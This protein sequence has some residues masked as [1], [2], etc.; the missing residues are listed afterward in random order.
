LFSDSYLT[1]WK[2]VK[3]LTLASMKARYRKTIAGFLWVVASPIILYCI[4]SVVFRKFLKLDIPDYALFLLGGL[5]PWI[6]LSSTLEMCTPMFS[7]RSELLKSF[8][9]SPFVLI[10]SQILDNFFNFLFAFIVLLIPLVFFRGRAE[11]GLLFLPFAMLQLLIGV[12]G[13][14]SL[15]SLL[16]VFYKDVRFVIPFITNV[17]FFL[18][19]I[20][21]P[22]DVVPDELR[23][24]IEINPFYMMIDPFR[25]TLYFFDIHA[26]LPILLKGSLVSIIFAMSA[27]FY[28]RRKRNEFYLNL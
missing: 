25:A 5:L 12:T 2:Q 21:Y 22:I 6:F 16:Q 19:P 3:T 10:L 20:F 17:F 18:T 24:F 15:F 11:I 1:T 14:V 7:T 23:I 28:W 8:K 4:Q 9:I 26:F 27:W 13:F